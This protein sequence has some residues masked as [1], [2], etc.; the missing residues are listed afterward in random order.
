MGWHSRLSSLLRNI[1]KRP[2][3]ERDL[4][5]ELRAYV[6]MAADER[7]RAGMTEEAARRGALLELQGFEQVKERVR[8]ARGGAVFE[9]FL[10]DLSY[11]GRMFV[12]NRGF[13]AASV[14]TLAL[15][16]GATTAIFS[17]VDT[18]I[19]RPLPYNDPERLVK[20]AGNAAGVLTDDV[21]FADFADLRD[22]NHV[23]EQM[24]ADD[25]TDYTVTIDGTPSQVV[26]LWPAP[27]RVSRLVS[28]TSSGRRPTTN[29]P[30]IFW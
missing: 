3:V 12:K 11:A 30:N 5:A 6:D 15:G 17:I 13:T 28:A 18:V 1:L 8:D 4:D 2:H 29:S 21:S 20:I 24:A 26:G 25:G 7:R 16:I 22:R 14:L 23:F 27:K 9:Q 19:Y 10:Q